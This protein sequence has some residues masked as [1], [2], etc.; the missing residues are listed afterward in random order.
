MQQLM[1]AGL[2]LK[3]GTCGFHEDAVKY[4]R[5]I[6]WTREFLWMRMNLRPYGIGVEKRK[7]PIEG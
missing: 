4:L 5:L 6:I 7:L 3:P 1:V 2:Y